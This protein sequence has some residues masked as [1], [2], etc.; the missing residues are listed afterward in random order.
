M[1]NFGDEHFFFSSYEF[2]HF[3][4]KAETSSP[5]FLIPPRRTSAVVRKYRVGNHS[6]ATMAAEAGVRE[7]VVTHFGPGITSTAQA[8]DYAELM[9]TR[10]SGPVHFANDLDTF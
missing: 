4:D 10:Y 9:A 3:S 7:V 6:R 1:R 2:F 5:L 8:R